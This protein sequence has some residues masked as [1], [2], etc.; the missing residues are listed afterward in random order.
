VLDGNAHV[1]DL[2]EAIGYF[3]AKD[4]AVG[5]DAPLNFLDS[6]ERKAVTGEEGTAFK[7]KLYKAQQARACIYGRLDEQITD[8]MP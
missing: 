8:L 5:R 1:A 2:V 7:V 3:K 6:A 4:G